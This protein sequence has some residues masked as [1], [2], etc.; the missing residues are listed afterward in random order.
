MLRQFLHA[1]TVPELLWQTGKL[2]DMCNL[3]FIHAFKSLFEGME[4]ISLH[5]AALAS[6]DSRT[7]FPSSLT[8]VGAYFA[9]SYKAQRQQHCLGLCSEVSVPQMASW[10]SVGSA[11]PGPELQD[12]QGYVNGLWQ[13]CITCYCVRMV[14]RQT[15][16]KYLKL[17]L[18]FTQPSP[19]F[20]QS[21]RLPTYIIPILSQAVISV[22]GRI[23]YLLIEHCSISPFHHPWP[24]QSSSAV[25][26]PGLCSCA[27]SILRK[28]GQ[29]F[30]LAH[31][32]PCPTFTTHAKSL[33][34]VSV[35]VWTLPSEVTEDEFISH[36]PSCTFTGPS[37]HKKLNRNPSHCTFLR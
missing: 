9:H 17:H 37:L 29:L 19:Y 33:V 2:E 23:A 13:T 14:S 22:F 10:H 31:C 35:L 28:S 36:L 1:V 11:Q 12:Q 18:F 32:W 20:L 34:C 3:S 6:T 30:E 25:P 26:K 27:I 7:S 8:R 15:I 16:I 21:K 4:T 5:E 24:W